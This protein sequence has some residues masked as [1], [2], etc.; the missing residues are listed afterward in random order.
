V[1][2]ASY[3]FI[4]PKTLAAL[5]NLT[6]AART[7]V[8]GFMYGVHHSRMPGAG[9]LEFSQYRSYQPGD[10]LR[11]VDWKLFARSDRYF[12][13]DAETDTSITVRLVLDASASMAHAEADLTKFD[14]G[15]LLAAALGVLAHRQGDAVGLYALNDG[16]VYALPPQRH[17]QHLHR[18]L[19]ELERLE[20]AGVWPE[21]S[22]IER[23]FTA[24]DRRGITVLI[25]DL[26]ERLDE[27]RTVAAKLMALRHE[28][29]VLHVIAR[30]ELEFGYR[31]TVTF[32]EIETGHR[33]A[34]DADAVRPAY[35]TALAE[36][37]HDLRHS[38]EEHGV[39][40][41]RFPIDQPLDLALRHYLTG[42]ERLR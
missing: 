42:R 10:D 5:R 25:T 20:P 17:H 4:D 40:Y 21:W 41:A 36:E 26:H 31:G 2:Y 30:A 38:L 7:V 16:A 1:S 18:L 39:G 33:V 23:L 8:D 22:R 19:H 28:V 29:L 11:R 3:R 14:Y 37:L 35:L 15:R 34:V 24:G 32:E 9:G 6:L 27:I 13:R 12:L